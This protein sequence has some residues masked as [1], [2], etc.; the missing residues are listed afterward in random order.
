MQIET[1]EV[2]EVD[3]DGKK[4]DCAEAIALI[5]KLNLEGQ[6]EMLSPEKDARC[7][8]RKMTKEEGFVYGTLCPIKTVIQK[9]KDEP[10]PLR[11]LQVAAHADSLGIY[12]TIEVWHPESADIKDPVLVGTIGEQYG[13]RE[14]YILARWGETLEAFDVLK[15]QAVKVFRALIKG[16]LERILSDVKAD[17]EACDAA[18]DTR[19]LTSKVKDPTYYSILRDF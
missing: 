9:F 7:P 3:A 18:S 19:V 11:V 4:E 17:I 13:T 1:Y 8:Y 10:I 12:R 15:V 2:T 6:R 5:E 16:K 14:F